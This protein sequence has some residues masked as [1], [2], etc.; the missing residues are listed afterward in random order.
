MP[1]IE[2]HADFDR[3]GRI[4]RSTLERESRTE[5]PGAIVVANLD[6]DQRVL[7]DS[8]SSA[9]TPAPD[10]EMV[11]AFARDDELLPLQIRVATGALAA[12]EKLAIRCSGIM[13]TRIRLSDSTG[14]IVHHRLRDP[15]RFELPDVP[16]N[17]E[18]N[19]T[20]QVRTIAG[21]SFGQLSDLELT[22][23]DDQREESQFELTLV[24][25]DT[26]GQEHVE[27]SGRFTVAPVI[28]DDC[29]TTATRI[30]MVNSPNNQPSV[31]D[32]RRALSLASV[33]LVEVS[34][35]LSGGDTWLQDQYQH[36]MMQGA[37]R[38]RQIILHLSRFRH[39][40]SNATVTD[41]LEDFVNSHF[42]SSDIAMFNDLWDR[43]IVTQTSDGGVA[44]ILF[45]DFRNWIA[46]IIRIVNVAYQIDRFAK[47]A[48]P[49][50]KPSEADSWV[51]IMRLLPTDLKRLNETIDRV[52]DESKPERAALLTGIKAAAAAM[53]REALADH[54]TTGTGDSMAVRTLIGGRSVS[55]SVDKAIRLFLRGRQ[56]NESSNYGGNIESTPPL[57]D[58]PLGKILLG[59]FKFPQ[60]N[61]EFVDPDLLRLL[62]KQKKQPIV[63]INTA[64][65]KVG[66]ID[67]IMAVVPHRS[68]GFSV[69]HA[70]SRAAMLLLR[71][72][73][74][75]YRSGVS[76]Y[77][78]DRSDV[79]RRPSGMIPRLMNSGT[80]PVT[81]MFRGKVWRHVHPR[82]RQGQVS[83]AL[84]PPAIFITLAAQFGNSDS[85]NVHGIGYIPGEGEDRYYLADITPSEVLFCEQ[86]ENGES[87][88]DS[89]DSTLLTSSRKIL[90]KQLNVPILP[91]PVIWDRVDNV[92]LFNLQ[93]WDQPTTAF[94][95]DMVN[96]QVVNGHLLIP[97]P[98]GP[99]MKK[100]EAVDVVRTVMQELDVPTSIRN[101]VGQRLIAARK[102]TR[103]IYWIERV[104]P[105][106]VFT[107]SGF[108]R[109]SY[110]G[111]STT[112]DVIRAFRDSFPG[113]DQK[114]LEKR[115]I[116][117]NKGRFDSHGFLKD[118]FNKLVIDDG[119]V[120]LFELFT[121]ALGDELG[122]KMHFVDSWFYH[123]N[124]G[125]I[126]CG[127]NVLRKKRPRGLSNVW[128]APNVEFRS[129][130]II[131]DE[132]EE[133]VH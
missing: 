43:K 12:G 24:R 54:S 77:H 1:G 115:I 105:A 92:G 13:H 129:Q 82:A 64:W 104:A 21:A 8:V 111:M 94:S 70:S 71:E 127:T 90:E 93:F 106:M 120:D 112:L 3:D 4:T 14:N 31:E 5:W 53:V 42:R 52:L 86:D 62:V 19:L 59:N 98:Y 109:T 7:P 95:P 17:G 16:R 28:L 69:L 15:A 58:A 34:E 87:I 10:Y 79:R 89:I 48:D 46:A 63:E 22:Y 122:V 6:S 118:R 33:P 108:I 29:L 57:P 74:Y 2:L 36:A 78:P 61:A 20:L 123:V 100:I 26:G 72:A 68:S 126:H 66:H 50:W 32:V 116:E 81:R 80:S 9:T 25:V 88:N 99:R 133:V 103:E 35:D 121:A 101:R 51:E 107:P 84:E 41:N 124:D 39:E 85:F 65:L 75:R 91:V 11:T 44:S 49:N 119:M 27:D 30:Y 56:M 67:E 73:D 113:A 130:T 37:T 23:R 114:E 102:M 96:L 110:G 18:L 40:N 131:F 117:P 45:R 128:D 132:A 83:Q 55:L 47:L 97:K 76:I 38:T 125:Q 60:T